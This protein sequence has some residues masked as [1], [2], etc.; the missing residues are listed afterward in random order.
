MPYTQIIRKQIIKSDIGSVWRFMSSPKNLER[1]TPKWMIFK[2]TSKNEDQ[3][4]YPGMIISYKVTPLLN[5]PMKWVTEIT[6]VNKHKYFIDGQKIGPYTLWHHEHKFQET[7]QG[8][9][10]TDIITYIPPFKILGKIANIIFIKKRVNK[11]FDYRHE[12]LE[13]IFNKNL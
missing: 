9:L 10:M 4:M 8:I 12:V 13:K 5:I 7:D 3:T 11:I 6:H 2:I 1:I